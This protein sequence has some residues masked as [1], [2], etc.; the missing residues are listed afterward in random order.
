[1]SDQFTKHLLLS[2][3][4]KEW[5]TNPDQRLCQLLSNIAVKS[6]WHN[7]DLFHIPDEK[8]LE[9]LKPYSSL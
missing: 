6:G 8:L 5:E 1:M 7:E 9:Y 4:L 2:A 3:I